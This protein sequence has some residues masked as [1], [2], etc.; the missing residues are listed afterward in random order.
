MGQND[1]LLGRGI[2]LC[3]AAAIVAAQTP[4]AFA[5]ESQP[6]GKQSDVPTS[7]PRRVVSG[8][9]LGPEGKPVSDARVAVTAY[10]YS[11]PSESQIDP[12]DRT[13][14][15]GQV[16][17]DGQGC[18]RLLIEE[19]PAPWYYLLHLSAFKS[20]YGTNSLRLYPHSSKYEATI[21]LAEEQ[22]LHGRVVDEEGRPAAGVKVVLGGINPDTDDTNRGFPFDNPP[23]GLLDWPKPA[24]S[25]Q[26][27]RFV[28]R[29]AARNREVYLLV[30]G[31]ERFGRH[32]RMFRIGDEEPEEEEWTLRSAQIVEGAVTYADTGNPAPGAYV[33]VE[34]RTGRWG[35]FRGVVSGRTDATGRFRLNPRRGGFFQVRAYP[36]KGDLHLPVD[37]DLDWP[38]GAVKREVKIEL[39]RPER[40]VTGK[41]I[42]EADGKP[43]AGARV[44]YNWPEDRNPSYPED[45]SPSFRMQ[46]VI[47]DS[48]GRFQMA[49][50]PGL[51]YLT[52]RAPTMDY[53]HVETSEGELEYGGRPFGFR[54]YPDAAAFVDMK[55]KDKTRDVVI[56]LRRGVTVHCRV[57]GPDGRPATEGVVLCRSTAP[58][59]IRY[60]SHFHL[61]IH[62]G[63]FELP[64]CDPK[65]SYPVFF[66]DVERQLGAAVELSGEQAEA[67]PVTVRLAPCG[68]AVARFIDEEGRA[69]AGHQ[70]Y[71]ASPEIH[72]YLVLTSGASIIELWGYPELAFDGFPMKSTAAD[73]TR[74]RPL[75][76]DAQGRVT[77]PTLIPGAPY[78]IIAREGGHPP[79][80]GKKDFTVKSSQTLDLGEITVKRPE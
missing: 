40:W 29:G 63:Q 16:K 32:I 45:V 4:V 10:R 39:P 77:F 48:D 5:S 78:R 73:L 33:T 67:G 1:T 69:F 15:L 2:P 34:S 14:L 43:V 80:V 46:E 20:G 59:D 51:S 21:Q 61:A 58:Y 38:E 19:T 72:M 44:M 9:V 22:A 35:F 55:P 65:K 13:A 74:Y 31:D 8:L 28:V 47:S 7:G 18:F 3:L 25:D 66:L 24:I 52:V 53:I 17:T 42:E 11:M 30:R 49:V 68:S 12:P 26:D 64:G 50:G 6:H 37:M 41:I 23:A 54:L 62:D 60:D 27:G 57:V 79:T 76:T 71:E 36:P 56:K 70:L 75:R